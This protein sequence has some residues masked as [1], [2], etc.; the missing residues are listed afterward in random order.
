MVVF[1]GRFRFHMRFL[2]AILLE[3]AGV[4]E[5]FRPIVLLMP[6]DARAALLLL[7]EVLAER[8]PRM[9]PLHTSLLLCNRAEL[10]RDIP[11]Q[12]GGGFGGVCGRAYH[13]IARIYHA[14]SRRLDHVLL[15]FAVFG[16]SSEL[17]QRVVLV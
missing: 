11:A 5:F 4:I 13:P 6:M 14:S 8:P 2:I 9:Q 3:I 17:G 16:H 15:L 7:E 1:G 12:R 10:F